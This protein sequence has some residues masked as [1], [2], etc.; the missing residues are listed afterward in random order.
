M[1]AKLDLKSSQQAAS[2]AGAAG[3]PLVLLRP[4]ASRGG[5]AGATPLARRRGGGARDRFGL[6]TPR[7]LESD[8]RAVPQRPAGEWLVE[9]DH[10]AY[11]FPFGSPHG[12]SCAFSPP[13]SASSAGE[14]VDPARPFVLRREVS[15][16][17]RHRPPSTP[18]PRRK[19]SKSARR[20]RM[21]A[22]RRP[23]SLF[24]GA[25][26]PIQPPTMKPPAAA[27]AVGD[28]LH[29]RCSPWTRS[30]APDGSFSTSPAPL[31]CSAARRSACDLAGGSRASACGA[32]AAAETGGRAWALARSMPRRG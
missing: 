22:P 20:S 28:A 29:A 23:E 6:V 32:G 30:T 4:G 5:E 18:P 14:P 10:A 7:R 19:E 26:R 27:R 9:F 2:R 25:R 1:I 13:A 11:R 12:R 16:T 21:R 24:A 3:L 15:G 8:A 17:P 31:I